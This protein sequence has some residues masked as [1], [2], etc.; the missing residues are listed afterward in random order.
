[1]S[2][3]RAG[4]ADCLLRCFVRDRSTKGAAQL[5]VLDTGRPEGQLCYLVGAWN[6]GNLASAFV[7]GIL[8]AIISLGCFGRAVAILG[9]SSGSVFAALCPAITALAAI[10]ILTTDDL[11]S[12]LSPEHTEAL[13]RRSI[14]RLFDGKYL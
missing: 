10:S 11:A 9:A 13:R 2:L 14:L 4:S 12:S 6:D 7:H 8:V 3:L 1:M 5:S